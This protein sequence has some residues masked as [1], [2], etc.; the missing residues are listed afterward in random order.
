MDKE[1]Q[2]SSNLHIENDKWYC[3]FLLASSFHNL[4]QFKGS[5]YNNGVLYWQFFPKDKALKL[6]EQLRTKTEPSIPA[7]DLFDAVDTFWRQV[8]RSKYS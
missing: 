7:K 2:K 6:I 8:S 3:P 5:S 1:I 4:I